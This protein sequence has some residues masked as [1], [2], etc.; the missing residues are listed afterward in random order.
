MTR[1]MFPPDPTTSGPA[2]AASKM[3]ESVN[4][5]EMISRRC[6]IDRD[7]ELAPYP[8]TLTMFR[9]I[10]FTRPIKLKAGHILHNVHGL[11]M[12]AGVHFDDY[13]PAAACQ[14]RVIRHRDLRAHQRKQAASEALYLAKWQSV[15]RAQSLGRNDCRV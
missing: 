4:T 15:D 13:R 6:R 3:S 7:V 10:P 12:R 5:C 8:T 9:T 1:R 2:I 11:R 14:G